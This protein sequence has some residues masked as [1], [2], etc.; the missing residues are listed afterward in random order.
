MKCMHLFFVLSTLG[1]F[2]ISQGFGNETQSSKCREKIYVHSNQVSVSQNGIYV[3]VNNQWIPT[4]SLH[5]DA[6]GIYVMSDA[7]VDEK[8]WGPM[9]WICPECGYQNSFTSN[10]C[11][12]CGHR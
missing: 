1:I 9:Y 3:N 11:E 8:K 10:A 4:D 5:T 2:S 6:Q 12:N 7:L